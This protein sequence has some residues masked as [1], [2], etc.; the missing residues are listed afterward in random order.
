[1][2][3]ILLLILLVC[4]ACILFGIFKPK[5]WFLIVLGASVLLYVIGW[6]VWMMLWWFQVI[7]L[8]ELFPKSEFHRAQGGW[9]LIKL[10]VPPLLPVIILNCLLVVIWRRKSK[11]PRQ[12]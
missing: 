9:A 1:M 10:F 6:Y 4:A 3:S 2:F 5:A 11:R 8:E 12:V 7:R